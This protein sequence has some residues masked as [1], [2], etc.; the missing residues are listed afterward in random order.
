M[1]GESL[2]WSDSGAFRVDNHSP[3]NRPLIRC[4]VMMALRRKSGA[5]ARDDLHP[6]ALA[7]VDARVR[8]RCARDLKRVEGPVA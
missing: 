2:F 4:V 1:I 8:S 6:A 7:H 5:G 3:L